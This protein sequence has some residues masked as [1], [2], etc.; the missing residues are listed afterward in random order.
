MLI[1]ILTTWATDVIGIDSDD[2][3]EAVHGGLPL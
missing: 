3:S 2:L 1:S